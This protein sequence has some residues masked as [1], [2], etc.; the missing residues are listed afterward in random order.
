MK[1]NILVVLTTAIMLIVGNCTFSNS[2]FQDEHV[3]HE[4][5]HSDCYC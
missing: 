3:H 5:A 4:T 1:K 2:A